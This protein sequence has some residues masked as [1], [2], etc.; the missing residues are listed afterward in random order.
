L[1]AGGVSDEGSLE[2]NHHQDLEKEVPG[3]WFQP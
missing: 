1:G 3:D 2:L